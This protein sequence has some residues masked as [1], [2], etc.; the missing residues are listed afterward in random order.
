MMDNNAAPECVMV[1]REID[2][3]KHGNVLLVWNDC[4]IHHETLEM[5]WP[6]L[7]AAMLSER[8]K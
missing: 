4:M 6:K 8:E 2:R 7:V 1:P 5:T 3:A